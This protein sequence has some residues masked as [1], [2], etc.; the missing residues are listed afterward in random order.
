MDLKILAA[1]AG[2][3]TLWLRALSALL[4]DASLS[5]NTHVG[6]KHL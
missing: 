5:P 1:G 4:E 2:E 6:N 3:M